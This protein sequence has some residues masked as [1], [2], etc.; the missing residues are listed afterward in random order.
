[1]TRIVAADGADYADG[2]RLLAANQA[3]SGTRAI[4]AIR[5]C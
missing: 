2:P 3:N 1:M 5:D 4:R